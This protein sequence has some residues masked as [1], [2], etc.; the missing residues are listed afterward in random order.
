MAKKN[1]SKISIPQVSHTF[2]D[3]LTCLEIKVESLS[4]ECT[5][6][7]QSFRKSS[8]SSN[9]F[10]NL[11]YNPLLSVYGPQSTTISHGW[12]VYLNEDK[13][14][15][16][17]SF[18]KPELFQ[19]LRFYSKHNSNMMY[20]QEHFSPH[21]ESIIIKSYTVKPFR[22]TSTTQNTDLLPSRYCSN[23][24]P[25]RRLILLFSFQILKKKA[26]SIYFTNFFTCL[27]IVHS[28]AIQKKINPHNVN[29][30]LYIHLHK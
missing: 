20:I 25:K 2:S 4:F 22:K 17:H 12:E 16:K 30:W 1:S 19:L 7:L 29:L 21:H 24:L 5:D 10:N 6:M 9:S 11:P 28:L 13:D 15:V 18:W 14:Q 26:N 8:A 23:I 3:I 27:S